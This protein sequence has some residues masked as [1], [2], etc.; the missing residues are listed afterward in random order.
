MSNIDVAITMRLKDAASS[1]AAKAL[2]GMR[3]AGRSV[4]DSNR[5]I[6]RTAAD[7]E[8][9]TQRT[10][11]GYDKVGR[12]VSA[13]VRHVRMV[14]EASRRAAADSIRSAER[15]AAAWRKVES[16][17]RGAGGVMRAAGRGVTAVGQ[18]GAGLAA[19]GYVVKQ[20][21]DKP[22]DFE[23][24]LA[25]MSNTAFSDRD[26][27]GRKAGMAEL[28]ETINQ[29]VAQGGGS[30]DGAAQ[31]LNAM[32]TSDALEADTAM[33]MLPTLQKYATATGASPEEL[34]NIAIRGVQNEY[35]DPSQVA[36]ALDKAIAAGQAGGFELKDMA[37]WLPQMMASARGMQ[38]MHGFETILAA[39][40]ASMTTAGDTDQ[41]GNNLV[42]L[43][44]KMSSQDVIGNFEKLKIDLPGTVA[45]AISKGID[46]LQAFVSLINKEVVGKDKAYLALQA[47]MATAKDD[48]S[49]TAIMENMA[50]VLEGGAIGQII[51][52]R[53]ALMALIAVMNQGEY[54]TAVRGDMANSA[55][56]GEANLAL[57]STTSSFQAELAAL[58]KEK[59]QDG[60]HE[61]IKEPLDAALAGFAEFS[62]SFPAL[63]T[64]AYAAATAIGAMTAAAAAFG[65][66]SLLRGGGLAALGAGARGAGAG[67]L[68][69]GGAA[70]A[71]TGALSGGLRGAARAV[72]YLGMAL[73]A[74]DMIA[75]VADSQATTQQKVDGVIGTLG[76][77]AGAYAGGTAGA[78]AG[79]LIGSVVPVIGTT[80]GGVLGGILG[81]IGGYLFG[82]DVKQDARE[83]VVNDSRRYIIRNELSLD[84]AVV[85]RK[86]NEINSRD[87]ARR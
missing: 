17:A 11:Q 38:G 50:S 18:A 35:F 45:A 19:G 78:A 31:A 66:L 9:A 87:M 51:Q 26:L 1:P 48:A 7:V 80:I 5:D 70:A 52:D 76:G 81:G 86:V 4:A 16:A 62:E 15:M 63:T 41:A 83:L 53:Q 58:A 8:R 79:A 13:V 25:D 6:A 67:A 64:A 59:A 43:F 24:M 61:A 2:E 74:A 3:R 56:V 32:L 28:R 42:N 60:L 33:S 40:Q 29:A 69:A 68:G 57:I 23:R 85:A 71:G 46:P 39:S 27:S 77:M 30:R 54:M 20:A 84:G 12:S 36:E 21:L 34:A 14:N 82:S 49:K 47:Q 72:P 22:I 73:G 75:T 37:R 44:A 55:G 10:A 65:A